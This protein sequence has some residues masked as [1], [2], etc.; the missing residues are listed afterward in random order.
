MG[1]KRFILIFISSLLMTSFC[2]SDVSLVDVLDELN[3][4][5]KW[6]PFL[7]LGV[8]E[9]S[10]NTIS[11]KN[12]HGYLLV[13][14]S[15]VI[16]ITPTHRN[17]AGEIILSNN[18]ASKIKT[19]FK[20]KPKGNKF[21]ISTII[22]DAGHGGKDPGTIGSHRINGKT[23]RLKEKDLVLKVSSKLNELLKSKYPEKSVL[24][25]RETDVY[26][27]LEERTEL[28]NNVVLKDNEAMI[29][30]SIHA[31]AS[32]NSKATGFEVWYL[33]PDYR[34]DL[35]DPSTV[36]NSKKEI[37]PILNTMLEEE[38]SVESIVLAKEI[39][40]NM[41]AQIGKKSD[42]RG[43][44]EESWFVVRN[45]KMPSVLI[46]IGFV[47][48]KSEAILLSGNDYLMKVTQ[49]IYNGVT[50]YI[51]QFEKTFSVTE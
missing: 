3:C 16:D 26:L 24:L 11:F 29:F 25:T 21:N 46:E 15:N 44:K 32:L 48:N 22:I 39:L 17:S 43:L 35:V 7:E 18:T 1:I 47:T 12:G 10:K 45:A 30:I 19:Y 20:E 8:I 51:D 42:N 14:Y 23:L 49:G 33:P 4:N 6:D 50:S 34:R 28:A 5:F 37:L 27:Q 9:D 2:F 40:K 13:N 36:D 41:D 31:N 38:F